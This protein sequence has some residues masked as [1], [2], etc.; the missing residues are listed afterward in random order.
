MDLLKRNNLFPPLF[1]II[2]K[3][4][5]YLNIL[6]GL[7]LLIP[8]SGTGIPIV[9][10]GENWQHKKNKTK[11]KKKKKKK[12][13]QN[14]DLLRMC[15]K[16]FCKN[17]YNHVKTDVPEKHINRASQYDELLAVSIQIFKVRIHRGNIP[18]DKL[19]VFPILLDFFEIK[20]YV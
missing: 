17:K 7:E 14:S 5:G 18:Q 19:T 10:Y 13:Q 15:L 1:I 11:Q 12:K 6:Y 4:N 2:N 3:I 20:Y 16:Y 9:T 8:S